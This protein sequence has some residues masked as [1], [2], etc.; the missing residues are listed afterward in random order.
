MRRVFSGTSRD[1]AGN[2]VSS[3]TV[4]LFEAGG[5]TAATFYSSATSTAGIT[6]TTSGS[7]GTFSIY[8]DNFD[9]DAE[10][11]F[12]ITIEK[13]GYSTKTTDNVRFDDVVLGTYSISADKTVTTNLVVPKGVIYSIAT[14][15]TLT[16]SGSFSAGDYQVFTLVGTGKVVLSSVTNPN[17]L[18]WGET[19]PIIAL[20][21]DATPSVAKSC[22]WLTGGTT[23]ITDFDDG[24]EGQEIL[25]IAEHSITITDGTNIFLN[26]SG[27]FVMAATDTLRLICKADGKWY[28]TGRSDN[29]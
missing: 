14:G 19:S 15:K 4:K 7:D 5:T 17:P 25:I 12:K 26:A 1:G 27:N 8:V 10:Q 23:T 20:D 16:I 3:A 9:Y 2:V 24:V 21:D 11:T 22:K 28:E 6:S 13:A 18:W 29:T